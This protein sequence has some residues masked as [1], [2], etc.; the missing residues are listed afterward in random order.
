M[1][2]P[3]QTMK[4]KMASNLAKILMLAGWGLLLAGCDQNDGKATFDY[5]KAQHDVSENIT[6]NLKLHEMPK[7]PEVPTITKQTT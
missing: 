4:T 5:L 2:E 1:S 7:P 3:T 6:A